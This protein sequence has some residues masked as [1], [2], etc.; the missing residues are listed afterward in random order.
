MVIM[1]LYHI[2]MAMKEE[3]HD[4]WNDLMAFVGVWASCPHSSAHWGCDRI[5]IAKQ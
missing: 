4:L 3:L 2:K 1:P 5:V